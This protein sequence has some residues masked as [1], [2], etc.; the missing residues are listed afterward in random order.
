MARMGFE[1]APLAI[2]LTQQLDLTREVLEAVAA[3]AAPTW[4]WRPFADREKP[5]APCFPP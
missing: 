5:T 4:H 3:A 2:A 1:D